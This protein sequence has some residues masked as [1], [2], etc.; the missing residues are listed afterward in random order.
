MRAADLS[1]LAACA[2]RRRRLPR[3]HSQRRPQ[4]C[5]C[6]ARQPDRTG[7]GKF[8]PVDHSVSR[9]Y[10][11]TLDAHGEVLEAIRL[12]KPNQAKA[13]MSALIDIAS[14][15]LVNA[16]PMPPIERPSCARKPPLE[17]NDGLVS[18]VVRPALGGGLARFDHIAHGERVP[19]FRPEP[20]HGPRQAFDLALQVLVPWSN[21][22]SGGGFSFHHKR[23]RLDPN[24]AGEPYPIHG[25]GFS[26]PW[27]VVEQQ[28]REHDTAPQFRR[29]RAIPLFRGHC[30]TALLTARSLCRSRAKNTGDLALPF[31]LGFHLWIVR[32]PLT[33]LQASAQLVWLWT[34]Q[35]LPKGDAPIVIPP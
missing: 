31:G 23:Y 13:P 17:I 25:N 3:Q 19:L 21:R 32:T 20:E 18:V 16:A 26:L 2:E 6:W 7:S 30:P 15:D 28:T 8:V 11:E 29:A 35:H 5:L 12:R 4:S 10:A 24:L 1:D 22:V 34:K 27:E 33:M 14:A 9:N